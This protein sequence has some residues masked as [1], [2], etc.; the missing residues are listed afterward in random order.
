MRRVPAGQGFRRRSIA[1]RSGRPAAGRRAWCGPGQVLP[2]HA[3]V[4]LLELGGGVHAQ[5]TGEQVARLRVLR[6]R[7]GLP[8][9]RIQRA[10]EQP[11]RAFGHRIRGDHGTQ[12]AD[13]ALALTQGQARLD[14]VQLGAGPQFLQPGGGPAGEP[15]AR[16]V[17]E[18]RPAPGVQ[19]LPQYPPG[20]DRVAGG[21]RLTALPRQ[22]LEGDG[23]DLPGRNRQP[24]AGRM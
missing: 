10:Q 1:R 19:G 15:H 11:A 23:V 3:Q 14:Q 18:R 4:D 9:G 13:Q 7:F 8:P 12:L 2:E 20:R 24:V 17:R 16:G 6:D 22:C 21:K 5:L